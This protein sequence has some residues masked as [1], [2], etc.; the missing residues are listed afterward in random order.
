MRILVIEDD[1]EMAGLIADGLAAQGH[2]SLIEPE[3]RPGLRRAQSENCDVLIVDRMLPDIDGADLVA[4]MRGLGLSEP[5]LMLTSLGAIEDRVKGLGSGA[6]DYLVKP[7]AMAE[8][9]AR[10][11]ALGR[12][13]RGGLSDTAVCGTIKIDRVR[14]EVWREGQRIVLQPREFELLEQLIRQQDQVVSRA[15][16][17]E[18]V[19]HF[20]FDPQTN[21]VETH[22]S[23]LR[24]KLNADFERDPI[25]TVRG[26]GYK[27]RSD[28]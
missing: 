22:M 16:L 28:A 20:H 11:D 1:A 12:R 24:Q 18:Q 6:D 10:I 8:L 27:L 5:I 9:C 4:E 25:Q 23:R 19:W 21:I 13:G 14:R 15:M 17:L 3:G 26:V 2:V 7:F